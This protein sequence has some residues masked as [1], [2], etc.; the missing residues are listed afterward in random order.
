MLLHQRANHADQIFKNHRKSI[1][2]SFALSKHRTLQ[3]I[4]YP[5]EEKNVLEQAAFWPEVNVG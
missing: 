2:V 3:S 4:I 5:P 1:S